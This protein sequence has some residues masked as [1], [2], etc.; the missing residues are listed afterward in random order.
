MIRVLVEAVRSISSAAE[1]MHRS[2]FEIIQYK[3]N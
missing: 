2:F 1:E 3:I